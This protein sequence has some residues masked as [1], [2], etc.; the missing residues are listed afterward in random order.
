MIFGGDRD[1]LG[2][3]I[4][5]MADLCGLRDWHLILE[6]HVPDRDNEDDDTSHP[7]AQIEVTYGRRLACIRV[8]SDWATWTPEE[9]RQ[10]VIHE[11]IHCHQEPMRWSINNC[12]HVVSPPMMSVLYAAFT[13]GMER[14]TDDIATAWAETLPLPKAGKKKEA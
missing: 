2:V 5:D 13:D 9:L 10:T 14:A 4:R 11:L 6:G 12:K 7:A 8:A 1:K 3:Y